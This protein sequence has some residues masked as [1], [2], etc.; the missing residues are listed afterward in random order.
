MI[1][2]VKQFI[3]V[4]GRLPDVPPAICRLNCI[5]NSGKVAFIKS[6]TWRSFTPG[7]TNFETLDSDTFVS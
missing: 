2:Y 4:S 3:I 5:F 6:V 1:L 7:Q